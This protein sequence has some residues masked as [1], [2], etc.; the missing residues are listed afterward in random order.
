MK[1]IAGFTYDAASRHLTR[2][3]GS[4]RQEELRQCRVDSAR[5]E[6]ENGVLRHRLILVEGRLATLER[7]ADTTL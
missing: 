3:D 7:T 6:T 2:P 4:V 1:P 5:L